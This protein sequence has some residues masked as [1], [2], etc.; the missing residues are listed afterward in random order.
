MSCS[1]LSKI[2]N[3]IISL[4]IIGMMSIS[5]GTMV[6]AAEVAQAN[7]QQ[8]SYTEA[9]ISRIN[10]GEKIPEARKNKLITVVRSVPEYMSK[11]LYDNGWKLDLTER[12]VA[13]R[14]YSG[15]FRPN[16][17]L[18]STN[19]YD[20]TI[21]FDNRDKAV[22]ASVFYHELGHVIDC[23][24]SYMSE[25][26]EV[27]LELYRT[28]SSG[29]LCTGEKDGHSKSSSLEYFAACVSEYFINNEQFRVS[30]PQSY[31]YIDTLLKELSGECQ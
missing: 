21:Y 19:D 30:A 28:E 18:A 9:M 20:M 13:E 1:I 31:C 3:S 23:M 15:Y 22:T 12:D 4:V 29:F 7:N 10:F 6:N 26:D 27:W 2:S 5:G 24:L 17:V 25:T 14:F 16:T 8:M 11:I